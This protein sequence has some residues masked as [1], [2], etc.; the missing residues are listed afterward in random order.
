[1][2]M[3]KLLTVVVPVYKV[4][5]YINKCLDSL[6]VTEEQMKKLEVIVVNDGNFHVSFLFFC[7]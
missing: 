1:M 7:K 4:E 2:D 6:I 5:K 3:D